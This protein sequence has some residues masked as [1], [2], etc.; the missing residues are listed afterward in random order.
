MKRHAPLA[1]AVLLALAGSGAFAASLDVATEYRMR[2]LSYTNLNLN[3]D[4]NNQAFISQRA[5]LGFTLK[6]IAIGEFRGESQSMDVSIRLHALGVAGSTT[7]FTPPF[8]R[9][10]EHYPNTRL[11]PFIENAFMRVRNLGGLPWESTFGLQTFRLGSGLLLDDDGAG[12]TGFSAKGPLPWLDMRGQLFIFQPRNNQANPNDL[13]AFG[14][15]LEIP[16]EGTWQL[17]QMLERDHGA[18]SLALGPCTTNPL[19]ACPAISK[20]TRWFSSLHY[21]FNYGP[22]VLEAEAALEKGAATPTGPTPLGNHI[23]YN[24]NAQVL[25]A[26]WRQPLWSQTQGIIRLLAARGSGDDAG[27]PTTDEAFFPSSGH[28]FDGLERAGWGEFFG[29][30]PYDA[31]GGQSTGTASGLQKGVSGIVTVGVGITPPAYYGVVLDVDYYLYQ[32]DRN[33]IGPHRNLGTELDL[34]LRYDVFDRFSL[35]ASAAF[36]KAGSALDVGMSSARRYMLEA[37]G[38]F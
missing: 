30:T 37:S 32:A 1:A 27:T 15:S 22:M 7:P 12:L 23:T 25:R 3:S 16:A 34:R 4:R 9:I 24:G 2:A 26:K 36:F 31:F 28:R 21:D 20:A 38:R 13:E 35:K 29:A 17:N 33:G 11:D 5:R 18:K 10:S 8:D 14:F 19:I 6:D